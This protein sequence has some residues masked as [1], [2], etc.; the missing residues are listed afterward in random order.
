MIINFKEINYYFLSCNNPKRVEHM[1]NEFKG[2]NIKEIN[3]VLTSTGISKEQSGSTGFSKMLDSAIKDQKSDK[4]TSFVLFEDDI[5]KYRDIPDK[6]DIPDDA[7]LLYVGLSRWGMTDEPL[8]VQDAICFTN[9]DDF[10]ELIKVKNMLSTH[11]FIVCSIRGLLTLQKCLFED[12]YKNR[13]YDMVLACIQPYI[14]AYALRNPLVYQYAQIG[15]QEIATK[16]IIPPNIERKIPDKW[17]N[18]NNLSYL[19]VLVYQYAPIGGQKIAT[20][21]II[22][23]NIERKIPDKWLNKNNLSYLTMI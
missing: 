16:I 8:G 2:Y 17:L 6:I 22:N 23:P 4:F 1:F 21:I 7:D 3:P 12:Y 18:K 15:G 10:P 11:G 5:K 13:G 19:N 20:K 14:N 9:V